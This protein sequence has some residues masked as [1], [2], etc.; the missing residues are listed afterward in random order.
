MSSVALRDEFVESQSEQI[1]VG[2]PFTPVM[3]FP[4]LRTFAPS[5]CAV[6]KGKRSQEDAQEF[7]DFVLQKL[8]DELK[9]GGLPHALRSDSRS[10]A[11]LPR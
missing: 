7:L 1:V 3:L 10:H 9:S 6:E 8:H 2:Q 4:T 11:E 5:D